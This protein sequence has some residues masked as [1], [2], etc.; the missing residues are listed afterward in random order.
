M[1]SLNKMPKHKF[2][3][4]FADFYQWFCNFFSTLLTPKSKQTM[5]S[6][7]LVSGGGDLE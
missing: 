4:E 1:P 2:E 3:P 7:S 6:M 5:Y